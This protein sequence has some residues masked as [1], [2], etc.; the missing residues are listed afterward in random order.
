MGVTWMR[1]LIQSKVHPFRAPALG[2]SVGLRQKQQT[3]HPLTLRHYGETAM[4][5]A[6]LNTG[7]Q[8]PT[9]GAQGPRLVGSVSTQVTFTGAYPAPGAALGAVFVLTRFIHSN[10]TWWVLLRSP[11]SPEEGHT[12]ISGRAGCELASASVLTAAQL[13]GR[14]EGLVTTPSRP[15]AVAAEQNECMTRDR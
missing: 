1:C 2:S 15:P 12:G 8:R 6:P 7:T 3:G 11:A 13:Q 14:L 9:N 10:P 4:C 5:Q